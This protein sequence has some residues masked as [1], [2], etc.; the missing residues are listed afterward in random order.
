MWRSIWLWLALT[1]WFCARRLRGA[2][3]A[4][5]HV[6]EMAVTSA[7]VPPLSVYW[8]L[9][10]AIHNRPA[11]RAALRRAPIRAA[12]ELC[13]HHRPVVREVRAQ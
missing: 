12:T 1:A 3:W 6:A 13:H 2:S 9:R 11:H 4:P 10:G 8:R 7:L 5:R